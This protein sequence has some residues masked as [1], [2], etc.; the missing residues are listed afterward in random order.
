MGTKEGKDSLL[1][2]S[3]QIK[4]NSNQLKRLPVRPCMCPP[5]EPRCPWMYLHTRERC[6]RLGSG[7]RSPF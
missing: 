7:F 2:A 5:I 1:R 3:T 4:F 6:L